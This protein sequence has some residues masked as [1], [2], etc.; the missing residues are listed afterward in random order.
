[1]L[2]AIFVAV[3]VLWAAGVVSAHMFGGLIHVLLG[4][5]VAIVLIRFVQDHPHQADG[6]DATLSGD[7]ADRDREDARRE[8]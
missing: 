7:P 6:P 8:S 2:W 5:G 1:M 3:L 4:I